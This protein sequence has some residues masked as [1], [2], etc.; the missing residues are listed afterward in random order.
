[1]LNAEPLYHISWGNDTK[2]VTVCHI[3]YMCNA[4][5]PRLNPALS[6]LPNVWCQGP[7]GGF[8]L[9]LNTG[10]SIRTVA[11]VSRYTARLS[12]D[13][14]TGKSGC[15]AEVLFALNPEP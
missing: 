9:L 10:D 14:G 6:L 12:L 5:Y 8:T 11:V 13:L 1:M 3:G 4:P 15:G 7:S 2:Q